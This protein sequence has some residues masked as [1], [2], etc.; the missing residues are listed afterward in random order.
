ML[1]STVCIT[2][3]A[4]ADDA[5]RV[6]IHKIKEHSVIARTRPEASLRRPQFL[7]FALAVEQIAIDAM[8]DC[9]CCI[10]IN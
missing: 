7:Y 8:Q 10:T 5:D 4:Y 2:A 1:I 9:Y 3:M 6:L